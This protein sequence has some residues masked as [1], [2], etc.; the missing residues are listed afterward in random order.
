MSILR[1]NPGFVTKPLVRTDKDEEFLEKV[2][3]SLDSEY[4]SKVQQAD[5]RSIQNYFHDIFAGA[6]HLT[7]GTQHFYVIKH[8]IGLVIHASY[9]QLLQ[10]C[11]NLGIT[12]LK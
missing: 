10:E 4:V 7:V 11:L 9:K 6:T 2:N 12:D 8:K 3:Q 5:L 1:V